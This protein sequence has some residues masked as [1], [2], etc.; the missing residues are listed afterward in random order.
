MKYILKM[1]LKNIT[2]L[3]NVCSRAEN[4]FNSRKLDFREK[5]V[6]FQENQAFRGFWE[7]LAQREK[8]VSKMC[9]GENFSF[10]S[11]NNLD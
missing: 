5:T 2:K 1:I 10:G 4:N 3:S 8:H 7:F 11:P 9:P 6:V